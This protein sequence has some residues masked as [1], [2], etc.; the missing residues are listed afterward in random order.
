MQANEAEW[1]DKFYRQIQEKLG[2]W[3]RFSIPYLKSVLTPQSKLVE[4]GCGQGH[5]LRYLAHEK[6][7]P[8]ENLYGMDQSLTAVD[9]VKQFIPKAN[10]STGDIYQL[11]YP[12]DFFDICLLLETIEHFEDPAPAMDQVFSVMAPGG[13]LLV[14]FPNYLSL[15]WFPFRLLCEWINKPECKST[16]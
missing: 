1:Y 8:E 15:P 5:L 13:L 9:F 3:H 2:S 16:R 14:S 7:L 6:L 4:L 12:K 11:Q 10:L